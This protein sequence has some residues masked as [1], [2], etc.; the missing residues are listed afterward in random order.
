MVA[1]MPWCI[2]YVV[3]RTCMLIWI[4]ATLLL[5]LSCEGP[6]LFEAI[7][8]CDEKPSVQG[9]PW[10]KF[11]SHCGPSALSSCMPKARSRIG[12]WRSS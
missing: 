2:C 9:T 10:H 5:S 12:L 4:F 3:L 7:P 11:F 8:Y 1:S 6:I